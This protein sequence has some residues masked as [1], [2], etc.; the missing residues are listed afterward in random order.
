MLARVIE[1]S[2]R[3]RLLVGILVVL[4]V[5]AGLVAI[6]RTPLDAIP[7]LSDVQVII[8]TDFTGQAP[9]I[10]ED[11]VTY[12]ISTEMSKASPPNSDFSFSSTTSPLPNSLRM[13]TYSWPASVADACA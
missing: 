13:V 1:L 12:P 4:T 9:Q 11:Q 7:D 2:V 3:N 10:V 5:F 8:Q 6:Q